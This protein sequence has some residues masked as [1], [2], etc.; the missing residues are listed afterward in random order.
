MNRKIEITMTPLPKN[1]KECPFYYLV[2]PDE[3]GTWYEFWRC[4]LG[5]TRTDEDYIGIALKRHKNCPL[6]EG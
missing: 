1:C 4:F 6:K 5:V 3:E 2:N